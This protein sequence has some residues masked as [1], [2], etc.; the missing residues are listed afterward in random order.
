MRR[1]IAMVAFLGIFG[2]VC[3]AQ[4]QNLLVNGDLELSP[5]FTYYD[6]SDLTI[7]DDVPGWTLL[8]VGDASSWVQVAFDAGASTTD[9]DLS[10]SETNGADPD[11][12]GMSGLQTAVLSR[13]AVTPA[14]MYSATVTYDNYF[15]PAGISYFIDWFDAGGALLGSAGGLL[16]DPN[17]P[18][19]FTPYTQLLEVAGVA[20]AGAAT[21]GVRFI[22]E[23]GSFAGATA[24]NFTLSSV[25]EPCSASMIM[26]AVLALGAMLRRRR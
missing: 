26:G 10:G 21:A 2:A 1:L 7:A 3:V 24:D 23:N 14:G 18:P 8:S 20:P 22:S 19:V 16:P 15:A 5:A 6:G 12:I 9:V 25:P 11:F 4:A 17:T 13:P